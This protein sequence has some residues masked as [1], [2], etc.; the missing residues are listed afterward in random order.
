MTC[1]FLYMVGV[2]TGNCFSRFTK[3]AVEFDVVTVAILKVAEHVLKSP[4]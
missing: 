3:E 1:T 4:H 2:G